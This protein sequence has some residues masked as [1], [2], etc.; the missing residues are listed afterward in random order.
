MP[1]RRE[2][3]LAPTWVPAGRAEPVGGPPGGSRHKMQPP[4][5]RN[6]RDLGRR[7]GLKEDNWGPSPVPPLL[8]SHSRARRGLPLTRVI[9]TVDRAD[10]LNKLLCACNYKLHF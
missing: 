7:N 3:L 2:C 9:I 8:A 4:V 10:M 5:G 6:R 1:P